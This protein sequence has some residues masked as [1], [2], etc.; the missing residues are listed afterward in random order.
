MT[1]SLLFTAAA[2]LGT[3]AS[4]PAQV[5]VRAPFVHVEVGGGGVYVRAPFVRYYS[6]PPV[7]YAPPPVNVIPGPP[8]TAL[9]SKPA[10]PPPPAPGLGPD[11]PPPTLTNPDSVPPP[12][13]S[14]PASAMTLDQ[15]SKAFQPQQGNYD[16][17]LIN[18][19]TQQPTTVRFSLPAGTPQRVQL[20]QAYIEYRY[21]GRQMVRIEFDRDGATVITR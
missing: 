17:L 19:V 3:T 13:V 15:F 12:P 1:R 16:I 20:G 5:S 9:P 6:G 18:P 10:P 8:P 4:A 11:L 7:V 2:I 21:T 14:A